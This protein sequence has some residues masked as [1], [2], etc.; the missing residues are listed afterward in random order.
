VTREKE[1]EARSAGERE[2]RWARRAVLRA[3]ADQAGKRGRKEEEEDEEEKEEK[4]ED[5]D[6]VTREEGGGGNERRAGR[7]KEGGR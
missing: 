5:D 2:E 3:T 1:P 7:T 4:S 6:E